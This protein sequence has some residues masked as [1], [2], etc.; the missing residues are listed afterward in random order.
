MERRYVIRIKKKGNCFPVQLQKLGLLTG[1]Q[2]D[3]KM[4]DIILSSTCAHAHDKTTE[5]TINPYDDFEF[6]KGFP[7][8]E[9]ST[10]FCPAF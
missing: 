4:Q 7:W 1:L 5:K 3:F 8:L 9:I 2:I 10:L 6:K